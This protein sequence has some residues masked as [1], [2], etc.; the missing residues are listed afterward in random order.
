[1]MKKDRSDVVRQARAALIMAAMRRSIVT[2]GELGKAL[3]IDGVALRNELRHVL[4]D[5]SADCIV[6]GEPSLAAL[7]VNQRTGAPGRGWEDGKDGE[8]GTVPWHAGVQ[9]VFRR[10]A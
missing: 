4:D 2:Y 7:V 1:M 10:W 8:G 9:A 3:G 5:L 6:R